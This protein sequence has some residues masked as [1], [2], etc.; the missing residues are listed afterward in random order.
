MTRNT[1]RPLAAALVAAGSLASSP[2]TA[3][4]MVYYPYNPSF[5]GNPL[6]GAVLLN[7]AQVT[8]HHEAPDPGA[9]GLE[10]MSPLEIF[11]DT[12][13]RSIISR[14]AASASSQIIGDD[15][16]FKP[17]TLETANFTIQVEE[18]GGYMQITTIDKVSGDIVTFQTGKL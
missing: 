3:S 4:E 11:N 5:G 9:A 18:K 8:S 17:G 13:E 10:N 16:Q 7:N 1:L 15:G 2:A 6:N 12:L 14:L